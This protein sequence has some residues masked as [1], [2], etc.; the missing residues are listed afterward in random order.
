MERNLKPNTIRAAA[1]MS[2]AGRWN[3]GAAAMLIFL[4]LLAGCVRLHALSQGLGY[5]V[6]ALGMPALLAGC[7]WLFLNVSSGRVVRVGDMFA[8][9]GL[10]RD[11]FRVLMAW[12]L[13]LL[14]V[15]L[16]ALLFFIPGLIAALGYSMTFFI[17]RDNGDMSVAEAMEESWT[18][19]CGHKWACF[20]L[21]M[22]F[23]G[24]T[25]LAVISVAGILW[26]VPYFCTAM[27]EFYN[28]VRGYRAC[29]LG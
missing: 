29:C 22:S 4:L 2:L 20:R 10:P 6:A 7:Q 16:G 5:G 25:I 12:V 9:F 1:R 24:W 8:P 14:I 19:M 11:Y 27:A 28:R 26:L 21:W 18:M 17:L 13:I 23:I 15:A 3:T